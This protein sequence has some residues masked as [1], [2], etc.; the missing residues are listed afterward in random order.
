MEFGLLSNSFFP[1][2]V[3]LSISLGAYEFLIKP[4]GAYGHVASDRFN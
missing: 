1:R 3:S 2:V 4:F